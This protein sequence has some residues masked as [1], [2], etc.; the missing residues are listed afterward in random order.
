M[1]VTL[2]LDALWS[3]FASLGFALLFNVPVRTLRAVALVGAVGHAVRTALHLSGAPLE[4]A[5]LAGATVVG[6]MAFGFS[7]RLLAPTPV[8]SVAGVIP[9]VPGKFAYGA[10][11]G[12]LRVAS[13]VVQGDEAQRILFDAIVSAIKVGLIVGAI[14]AGIA[15]PTLLLRRHVRLA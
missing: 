2:L 1:M 11:L 13:G 4:L 5:T 7:R 3:A 6:F 15:M 8:F 12:F 10:M 9:M 14:A